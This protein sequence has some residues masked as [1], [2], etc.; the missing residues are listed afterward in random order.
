MS[1]E[2]KKETL[3]LALT[4]LIATGL[5]AGS[6]W[7]LR[8][9]FVFNQ[10]IQKTDDSQN[11]QLQNSTIQNETSSL[12][13]SLPNP[14]VLTIDGSMTMVTVLKQLQVAF[15]LLNPSLPVTYG[16]PYGKPNGTDAGIKNL[17]DGKVLMAASCRQLKPEEVQA[18]L[19]SVPIAKDALAVIVGS[20]NL[21]KGGLTM[22]QLKL[23]F[24]GQITNWLQVGGANAPIKV[25]NRSLNSDTYTF[26]QDVVLLGE[27]F[28]PDGINFKTFQKD[29]TT[30]ISRALG[31][32]GIS[33]ASVSQIKNDKSFR[34]VL[35]DGISPTNKSAVK[36]ASY[37]ITKVNYLATRQK[38][39]AVNK[40]FIDFTLSPQGQQIINRAGLIAVQ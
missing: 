13:T 28:A 9:S 22:E 37:P 40:Q 4:M 29:E 14:S 38:T 18:G 19:I 20:N 36:N 33:Y 5:A 6:L 23:I 7:Y 17:I 12:D 2:N 39:T 21:Y 26:F 24:Q 34:I 31:E 25:I 30:S 35:I 10:S 15:L 27:A 3:T 32:D 11:Q 8:G 16:V 1:K